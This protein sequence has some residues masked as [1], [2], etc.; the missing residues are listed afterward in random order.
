MGRF[1]NVLLDLDGTVTDPF[2]GIANSI[3]HAMK[4]MQREPPTEVALRRAIGPPLRQT[5]RALL[6]SDDACRIEE[7]LL[8]YRERYSVTGLFENRVYPDVPPLLKNLKQVGCALFIATSKPSVFAERII[9]HFE[10]GQY[11]DHVYGT[12]LDG[13]LENKTDLLRF[14]LDKE[15]L[16][17]AH[18]AM[19]GDRSHDMVAAKANGISAVGITWGYGSRD[20]LEKAGADALCVSPAELLQYLAAP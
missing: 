17:T 19:V 20:E 6:L 4:S 7:A 11:F 15:R 13:G 5:F 14:I 16:D 18:T 12:H 9:E 2:E 3:R 10:L 8:L 1:Q